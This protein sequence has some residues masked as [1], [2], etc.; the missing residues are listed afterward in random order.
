MKPSTI[1]IDGIRVTAELDYIPERIR[2]ELYRKKNYEKKGELILARKTL[3]PD[4]RVLEVGAG[5][6]FISLA[7]A[8]KICG[9]E[10]VLSYEPNPAMKRVIEKKITP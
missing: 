1:V 6:G 10:R 7:C 8:K 2:K 3:R 4:D 9:P 5:T